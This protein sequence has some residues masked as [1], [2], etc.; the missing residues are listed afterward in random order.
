MITFRK[1]KSEEVNKEKQEEKKQK[2]IFFVNLAIE[3]RL[4]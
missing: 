1:E 4:K 2:M 3:L